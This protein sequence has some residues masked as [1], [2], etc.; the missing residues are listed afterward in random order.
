MHNENDFEIRNKTIS[1]IL[2]VYNDENGK[3]TKEE[4]ILKKFH[5]REW[6]MKNKT[7][8]IKNIN[9]IIE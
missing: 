3:Q 1:N 4:K 6:L 7:F 5:I 8:N 2:K 9:E